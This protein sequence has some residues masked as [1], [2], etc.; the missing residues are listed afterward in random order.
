MFPPHDNPDA[1]YTAGTRAA[2]IDFIGIS[3]L[4]LPDYLA[5]FGITQDVPG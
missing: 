3:R 5:M 1:S 4:V 2:T